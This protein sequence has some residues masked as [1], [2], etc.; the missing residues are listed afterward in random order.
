MSRAR[1]KHADFDQ[2]VYNPDLKITETMREVVLQSED[3]ASLAYHLGQHPEEAARIAN[4]QPTAQILAIGRLQAKLEAKAAPAAPVPS[5]APAP[6][7]PVKAGA[8]AHAGLR[9]DLSIGDW[10]R[11]REAELRKR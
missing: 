10:M 5:T 1:E 7:T 8:P 11:R 4:L 6:I 3:G 2:V 9:E